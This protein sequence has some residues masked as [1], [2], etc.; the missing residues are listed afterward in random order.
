M[1]TF[2]HCPICTCQLSTKVDSCRRCGATLSLLTTVRTL[3]KQLQNEG[4][5]AQSKALFTPSDQ[6]KVISKRDLLLSE[7]E[8]EE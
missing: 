3:A 8:K 4:K 6:Q 1:F 2:T 7:V 5:H